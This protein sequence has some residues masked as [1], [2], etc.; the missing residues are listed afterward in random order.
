MSLEG[1][2][3]CRRAGGQGPFPQKNGVR[4]SQKTD[5]AAQQML[6]AEL[7]LGNLL[8]YLAIKTL[9]QLFPP[10]APSHRPEALVLDQVLPAVPTSKFSS[11]LPMPE[12]LFFLCESPVPGMF[13]QCL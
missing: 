12:L 13:H 7:G 10:R 3:N 1:V 9:C 4:S 8:S 6:T 2:R 11:A 5:G